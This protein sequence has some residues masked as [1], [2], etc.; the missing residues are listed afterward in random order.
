MNWNR[1]LLL[2][3]LLTAIGIVVVLFLDSR[4]AYSDSCKCIFW[5]DFGMTQTPLG[6]IIP[7]YGVHN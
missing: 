1:K 3:F 4:L 2:I 6:F 7:V 5:N